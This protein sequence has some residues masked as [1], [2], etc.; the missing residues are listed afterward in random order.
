MP[1]GKCSGKRQTAWGVGPFIMAMAR[2][3]KGEPSPYSFSLAF[4]SAASRIKRR[5][6]CFG[7]I[8]SF[9]SSFLFGS[10]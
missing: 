2:P 1:E 8:P 6:D 7:A 3:F 4:C 10:E 9:Q 5:G